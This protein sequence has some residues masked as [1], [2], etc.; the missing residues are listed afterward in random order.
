[1]AHTEFVPQTQSQR[2]SKG[3]KA[4]DSMGLKIELGK[5]KKTMI[6][7]ERFMELR[8]IKASFA[9]MAFLLGIGVVFFGFSGLAFAQSVQDG[10]DP[11]ADASVRAIAIQP[12]GKILVGGVFT[13]IGGQT[14]NRIARLNPDGTLDATFT[15]NVDASGTIVPIVNAIA[16]QPDGKILI[17]GSFTQVN[18]QPRNRIARLN[19][20]GTLDTAFNPNAD[21][22]V[23]ALIIQ[24]DG[25]ILVGGGFGTIGGQTRGTF[26]RLNTDG[27]LDLS[28]N[29]NVSGF[30]FTTILQTD[31]KILIGGNFS[32]VGGQTRNRI[33]RLNSDGSLDTGFNPDANDFVNALAI[34][35]DG[36]ILVG[37]DFTFI[38]GQIRSR[39]ARLNPDGTLDATFD[40]NSSASIQELAIQ[41][42][43]KILIGGVISTVGGQSRNGAARLNLDGSVDTSF[44]NPNVGGDVFALAL[45]N[46]GKVLIGGFFASVRG[47]TRNRIARL[48]PDGTLDATFNA[49][50]GSTFA[51]IVEAIAVQPDGKFI[52]GGDFNSVGGQTRNNIAR[53]TPDGVLDAA[54]NPN[55]SS[56][57]SA[58]VLQ[59]DGK[60]LIGGAFG[61]IGGQS[62]NRIARLNPDGTL[63][64]NFTSPGFNNNVFALALQPDGKVLV[65]GGFT[66]VGGQSRLGVARLN[67]DGTLDSSFNPNYS[68]IGVGAFN[69]I[70]IRPDGKILVG[71]S[72][73]VS[74][75]DGTRRG[76][77]L[78]NSD[79]TV[80]TSFNNLNS[81]IVNAIVFQPDGKI[82]VGA[83][84]GVFRLN[85]NG[86]LDSTFTNATTPSEVKTV[87]FQSD[88]KI[89][90]GG[91]FSQIGGQARDAIARLNA[92]GTVDTAFN[93]TSPTLVNVQSL[94]LQ[95]DGKILV[96]LGAGSLGMVRLTNDTIAL[97]SL[98]GSLYVVRP[99]HPFACKKTCVFRVFAP[100][101]VL[102]R[103]GSA[104]MFSRV[105]FELST[106][107]GAT[108]ST[109]G[110]AY[111]SPIVGGVQYLLTGITLPSNQNILI[112][113][114]G[115]YSSVSDGSQS[116]EER[117]K[118]EFLVDPPQENADFVTEGK[119]RI[120]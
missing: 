26:V 112:R 37:G 58:I 81:F 12:D 115:F 35:P 17:G 22:Q 39:I 25:K 51:P 103:R 101:V 73:L 69:A 15:V 102:V 72:F 70:A 1:M 20:D 89:L 66:Q 118:L 97:N 19:P 28:F 48:Y 74:T 36:K 94:A 43:G 4:N 114:R 46:D 53:F 29:P 16:I 47:Q 116:I 99:I 2:K 54:F 88:G 98:N 44:V 95:R 61:Q 84:G 34:Q 77:V 41:P 21:G 27:T 104:P 24:P 79:G 60:I 38:G 78:L 120:P 109:L 64:T 7:M 3:K 59:P 52:V 40:P 30:V 10:F 90:V 55:A 9:L 18:G 50:F 85:P 31:G 13:Q 56:T 63:D 33:A 107:G 92:N 87:V 117:L 119:I 65:S 80:D 6:V 106:D 11:N 91:N 111:P 23:L 67:S 14:R 8:R 96:G 42:D 68:S 83:N 100:S 113:A 49:T 62:R 75:S 32:S 82:I 105:V 110:E 108:Y 57:V 93:L 5:E 45:Q 86:S 76:M 71:G